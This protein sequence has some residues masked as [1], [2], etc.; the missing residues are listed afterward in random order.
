MGF[1]AVEEGFVLTVE[2]DGV[3]FDDQR[4][5]GMGEDL[6]RKLSGQLGGG[7]QVESTKSGRRARA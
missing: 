3:G 2:D 7:L 6:M 1:E 4:S 5:V